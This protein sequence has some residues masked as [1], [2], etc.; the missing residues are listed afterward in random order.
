MVPVAAPQDPADLGGQSSVGIGDDELYVA[1]SAVGEVVEVLDSERL[2]LLVTDVDP[3]NLAVP[4]PTH[5]GG[6]YHSLE[7]D[8]PVLQVLLVDRIQP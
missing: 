6:D 8:P 1:K 2:V 4:I 7:N 5:G 3:D